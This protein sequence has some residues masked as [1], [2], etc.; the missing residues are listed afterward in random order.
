MPT[1][2]NW[3]ALDDEGFLIVPGF[4]DRPTIDALLEGFD[5]GPPPEEYPFGFK[6]I[7]RAPLRAAWARIEPILEEIRSKTTINVDVINFLTLSHYITTRRAERSSFLHQDF[8]LDYKLTRDHLNYLNFWI[9][10]RKTEPA[11]SNLTVIPFDALR[12][13]SP[14][15][16]RRLLGSGGHRFVPT[17]GKTAVFGNYGEILDGGDASPQWVMDF[18]LEDIATTPTLEAGDLL[19]MRGDVIHR[20]QDTDTERVAAS[21]RVTF[22]GKVIARRLAALDESR[23]G[24]NG[25]AGNIQSLLRKCFQSVGRETVTVAEFVD[26]SRGGGTS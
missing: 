17:N 5:G 2:P 13:K 3:Q 11:K 7:G 25:A 8:D 16:H 10:L 21:V 18:N 12:A 4:L 9:P 15:D 14:H 20:T 26:F 22:S 23:P 19:L 1:R 24:A 6:L